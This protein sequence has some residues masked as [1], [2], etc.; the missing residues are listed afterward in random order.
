[1]IGTG[2]CTHGN[3]VTYRNC[4]PTPP[5]CSKWASWG[6]W[7]QCSQTCGAGVRNRQRSCLYGGKCPGSNMEEENCI[8]GRR[9]VCPEWSSWKIGVMCSVTCGVGM[10]NQYRTCV[11]G[12]IGEEGCQGPAAK[13]SQCDTQTECPVWGFWTEWSEC[14]VTCGTSQVTR[15]RECINGNVGDLGCEGKA[16]EAKV[17]MAAQRHCPYWSAWAQFSACSVSCGTGEQSRERECINGE[18]GDVG[19]EGDEIKIGDCTARRARCPAWDFWARWSSCSVSCGTGLKTRERECVDGVVGEEGC[20]GTEQERM[21]CYGTVRRECEYWGDWSSWYPCSVT[22]GQGSTERERPCING[23]PGDQGCQGS[24]DES[25]F[26]EMQDCEE[27]VEY[28][29]DEDLDTDISKIC[30]D[31][32]SPAQVEGKFKAIFSFQS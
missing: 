22:C 19:C 15:T 1:M 29:G 31:I 18:P 12:Q 30:P 6:F 20:I 21:E 2:S 5:P 7:S 23:N 27:F 4:E 11:N 25:Q 9:P 8:D 28:E 16:E 24:P 17:C 13:H 26:C 3:D 32:L 14:G 10:S